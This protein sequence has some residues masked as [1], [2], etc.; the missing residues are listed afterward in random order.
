LRGLADVQRAHIGP[1]GLGI[2]LAMSQMDW[3]GL[4]RHLFH[5]VLARIGIVGQVADIGDVDDVG[6]LVALERSVRPSTS[7]KT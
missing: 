5:L 1:I 6:E 2:V 7:A 4:R 3:P